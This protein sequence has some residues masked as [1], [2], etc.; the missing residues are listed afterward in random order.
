MTRFGMDGE[1]FAEFAAL[2]AAA[3][4][5]EPGIGEEVTRFR[6]R[7]RALRYCFDTDGLG[8][9]GERLLRTF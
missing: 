4:R 2:F 9:A 5:D 1:D 6:R 8:D 7:F 3:L